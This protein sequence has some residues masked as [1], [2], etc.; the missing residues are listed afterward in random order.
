MRS[1]KIGARKTIIR[2]FHNGSVFQI[3]MVGYK[4]AKHKALTL[5]TV[6]FV[7]EGVSPCIYILLGESEI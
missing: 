4:G 1:I 5:D 7:F 2:K 6:A 3:R